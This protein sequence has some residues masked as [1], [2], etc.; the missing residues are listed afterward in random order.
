MGKAVKLLY[1]CPQGLRS[2]TTPQAQLYNLNC[3][4]C[5]LSQKSCSK[6]NL[7]LDV[8]PE[9]LRRLKAKGWRVQGQP[10][11]YGSEM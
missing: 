3:T 8:V 11:P 10:E 7:E 4:G 6:S 1:T 9:A 5:E 2:K